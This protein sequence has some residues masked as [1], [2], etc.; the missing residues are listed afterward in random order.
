MS[1]AVRANVNKLIPCMRHASNGGLSNYCMRMSF[2]SRR[3]R[4]TLKRCSVELAPVARE[5]GFEQT[6]PAVLLSPGSDITSRGVL[7]FPHY[8]RGYGSRTIPH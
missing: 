7:P 6:G 4:R 1:M 8:W 2:N 5:W 3:E